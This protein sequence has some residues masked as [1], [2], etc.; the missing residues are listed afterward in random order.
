MAC[1][2]PIKGFQPVEGGAILWAERANTRPI[3]LPCGMCIGCRIRRQREWTV[4]LMC[5]QKMHEH[6]MFLT[7][8]YDEDNI[9]TDNGLC[10]RHVQLFLKRLRKQTGL[11]LRYFVAGEYGDK[12]LRPHYHMC[13]FG[14]WPSDSVR[15]SSVYSE[16]AL[17]QSEFVQSIWGKGF[18]PFGEVTPQS[19]AYTASYVLKKWNGTDREGRY[20]RIN[21]FTGEVRVVEREFAHMSLKPGIGAMWLEKYHPDLFRTGH[22]AMRIDNGFLPIPKYFKR[23]YECIDDLDYDEFIARMAEWS[24]KESNR[25]NNESERLLVRE[26]VAKAKLRFYKSQKDIRS[27][28]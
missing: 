1:F 19:A 13:L 7:L 18:A 2:S 16:H 3:E 23:L 4:R 20:E 28:V 24:D 6:S 27:E 21:E 10:Y 14:Y 11:K 8:T 9:P 15:S 17:Y 25:W 5:E 22:D 26:E 12:S